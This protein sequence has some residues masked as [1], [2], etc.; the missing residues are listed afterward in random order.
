[1]NKIYQHIFLI[2]FSNFLFFDLGYS[3]LSV[4]WG[5]V[6]NV[7]RNFAQSFS[8]VWMYVCCFVYLLLVYSLIHPKLSEWI[9]TPNCTL[10]PLAFSR[11]F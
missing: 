1:M 2:T 8:K 10:A 3:D 5:F 6:N 7:E 9:E 4:A 11:L